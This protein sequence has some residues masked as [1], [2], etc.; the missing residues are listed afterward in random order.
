MKKFFEEIVIIIVQILMFYIFPLF[1]HANHNNGIIVIIL[2]ATFMLAVGLGGISKKR[3]KYYYPIIVAILFIPSISI[4]NIKF[5]IL[6]SLWCFLA[7]A[8]GVII[9]DVIMNRK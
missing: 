6:H 9:G 1:V 2:L 3:I 4:Y 5:S 8:I 7:S